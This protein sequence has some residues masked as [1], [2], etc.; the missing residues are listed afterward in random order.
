M[1]MTVKEALEVLEETIKKEYGVV[2][3][4]DIRFHFVKEEMVDE[5]KDK[6]DKEF[7]LTGKFDKSGKTKWYKWEIN[8]FKRL[9][10]F[11]EWQKGEEK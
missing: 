7:G 8:T 3:R 11:F 4:I 9:V 2:P 5:V 10:L 6:I 1:E